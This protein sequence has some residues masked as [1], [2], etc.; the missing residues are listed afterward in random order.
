MVP[1]AGRCLCGRADGT[2]SFN[3]PGQAGLGERI[4]LDDRALIPEK[5]RGALRSGGAIIAPGYLTSL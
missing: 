1:A 3:V 4:S 5:K 2:S